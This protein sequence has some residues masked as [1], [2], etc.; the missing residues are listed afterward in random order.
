M[1]TAVCGAL[2]ALVLCGQTFA[3]RK[4]NLAGTWRNQYTPNLSDALGHEPPYTAYGAERWRTVDTSKDP[5]GFC[6]PPGPSRAF[7]A[8]FP[9][10][11]VQQ[12]DMIAFL[13]EY[14]TL[15][16]VVYLAVSYTHLRAH[17]T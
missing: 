11:L 5:T 17:E 8:P 3:Q 4:P 2:L 15:W 9:F 6:L 13:F 14:Q 1:K 7:T 16:R 10:I 12:D